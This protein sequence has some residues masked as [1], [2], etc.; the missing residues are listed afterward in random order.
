M[1]SRI[2]TL[3]PVRIGVSSAIAL[4]SMLYVATAQTPPPASPHHIDEETLK[5]ANDPMSSRQA[6]N[7]HNY[8]IP[9]LFGMDGATASTTMIRYAQPVGRWIFRGTLPVST[10]S[11]P[12]ENTETGL[13]DFSLFAIYKAYEKE[14]TKLGIGP[15]LTAPTGTNGMG[16]GKWQAGL[17]ALAFVSG[18]PI[19]Q[20]GGLVT[21]QISFA[22]N[23]SRSMVNS[24]S[25]QPFL[26]WQI[27]NGFC[28]RSSGIWQFD[29]R[30]G[31]YNIPV[32]L[33]V[34]KVIKVNNAICNIFIEPQ[35]SALSYGIGQ[36]RFQLFIGFNTQF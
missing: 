19:F 8:Y 27:G 10:L 24:L 11:V 21:W 12:G 35:Y 14:G 26:I 20:Y 2:L 17:S 1:K 33:G 23:S 29:L 18:D 9:S 7:L 31:N 5:A 25:A 15:A 34:G 6:L 30:S 3:N 16:Q 4:L 28:L 32:G 13:S 22:G 36:S